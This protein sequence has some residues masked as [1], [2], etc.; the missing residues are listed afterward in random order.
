MSQHPG[1]KLGEKIQQQLQ[2][3]LRWFGSVQPLKVLYLALDCNALDILEHLDFTSFISGRQILHRKKSQ[4]VP[5]DIP[6]S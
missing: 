2:F 5:A 6:Q 1:L 3:G 4:L